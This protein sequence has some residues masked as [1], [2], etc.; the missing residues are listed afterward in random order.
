[1]KLKKVKLLWKLIWVGP[2]AGMFIIALTFFYLMRRLHSKPPKENIVDDEEETAE[3][4]AY[5]KKHWRILTSIGRY[6]KYFRDRIFP[7][8]P[9]LTCIVYYLQLVL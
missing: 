3:C 4:L 1:M 6:G 5:A 2:E 9:S 8:C 7:A